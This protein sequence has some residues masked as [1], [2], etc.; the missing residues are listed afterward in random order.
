MSPVARNDAADWKATQMHTSCRGEGQGGGG[1]AEGRR[2]AAPTTAGKTSPPRRTRR[3][4]RWNVQET[5][6]TSVSPYPLWLLGSFERKR[7]CR[8]S[9]H[10]AAPA[11]RSTDEERKFLRGKAFKQH[12]LSSKTRTQTG[13]HRAHEVA[14]V[15]ARK[16]ARMLLTNKLTADSCYS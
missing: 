2:A 3:T 4:Q 10:T 15:D 16:L 9:R 11:K 5:D 7:R 8:R 1:K 13:P 14:D 6:W 12:I